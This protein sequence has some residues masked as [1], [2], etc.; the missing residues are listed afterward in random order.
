MSKFMEI[1]RLYLEA[2]KSKDLL[3]IEGMLSDTVE[4]E[5]WN[6]STK[7][8]TNF[9]AE[10]KKNFESAQD[11]EITIEAIFQHEN[12]IAAQLEIKIDSGSIVLHA[13][14][15]I[16]FNEAGQITSVRAYKG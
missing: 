16:S 7:G 2:Y 14:D 4:L 10:T 1:A 9:L 5:D 12:Q 11:I 15:V 3:R 8:K 6:L 13:V